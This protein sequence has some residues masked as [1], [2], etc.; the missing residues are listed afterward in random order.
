MFLKYRST[1]SES[2][3]VKLLM[4]EGRYVR[5]V[6]GRGLV[7]FDLAG[8]G[9]AGLG[10]V[11]LRKHGYILYRPCLFLWVLVLG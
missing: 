4:S 1:V 11:R 6:M 8:L 9:W 2:R 3:E 5:S 7:W 10:V